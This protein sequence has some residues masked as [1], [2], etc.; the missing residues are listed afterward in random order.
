MI[1]LG[2]MMLVGMAFG[3]KFTKEILDN[4]YYK[5]IVWTAAFVLILGALIVVGYNSGLLVTPC[6][7]GS[8]LTPVNS[9]DT[10]TGECTKLLDITG[11]PDQ[12]Y[13]MGIDVSGMMND[14]IT[15]EMFEAILG[16]VIMAAFIFFVVYA[17]VRREKTS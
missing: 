1:L 9:L 14:L 17:V 10:Q 4:K 12:I 7:A 8:G 11:F 6:S 15:G 2:F 3:E 13:M 5:F 16:L